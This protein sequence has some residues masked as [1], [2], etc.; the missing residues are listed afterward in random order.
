MF[1]YFCNK[2]SN[3]KP[4]AMKKIW[5]L[6]ALTIFLLNTSH[7]HIATD[8]EYVAEIDAWHAQRIAS[9][10]GENGW[11]NV[12]G[13]YW[14]K[15]GENTF[16]AAKSNDIVFP[17]GDDR[18]GSLFLENGKVRIVANERAEIFAG[19]NKRVAFLTIYD[20]DAEHSPVV[21]EHES[22]RWYIIKRQDKYG[23]RLRDLKAEAVK[24][25]EGIKRFPVEDKW[26]IEATLEPAEGK[27]V[28]VTNVIGQTRPRHS[29]GT[30]VFEIDGETYRLDPVASGDEL[31]VIFGD[32][33][34]GVET[35]GAGRFL[36]AAKPDENGKTILDFNKAYNPPCAFTAFATCPLP[37]AQNKLSV[38]I[39]AGEKSWGEH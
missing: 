11:L 39:L 21:L 31:F 9:L 30:L 38:E 22:L 1:Y 19:E 10:T 17:K 29:P 27:T 5:T 37:P 14:L 13:L 15:A 20:P 26:R 8:P 35:Y 4:F 33:T 36:Y 23:V 12:V 34:N 2:N 28:D 3:T 18:L 6:I 7:F 24:Q 32:A 25:F 16:G